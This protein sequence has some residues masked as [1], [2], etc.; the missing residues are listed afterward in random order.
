MEK[1]VLPS[2][3]PRAVVIS[4]FL[5]ALLSIVVATLLR[6][7]PQNEIWAQRYLLVGYRHGY[8]F[9]AVLVAVVF[10]AVVL[11][12]KDQRFAT[13][14]QP[15]PLVPGRPDWGWFPVPFLHEIAAQYTPDATTYPGVIV[16][17]RKP[18]V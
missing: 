16:W 13:V 4:C 6:A 9:V 12:W 2:R 5:A 10:C 18:G 7:H 11:M 15:R 8:V 1:P 3:S 14:F 17:R